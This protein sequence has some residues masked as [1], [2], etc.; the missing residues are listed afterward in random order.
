MNITHAAW[1]LL[2]RSFV[3]V[4]REGGL[5]QHAEPTDLFFLLISRKPRSLHS[6]RS[7][8]GSQT[9]TR[10]YGRWRG[11]RGI[12]SDAVSVRTTPPTKSSVVVSGTCQS[13]GKVICSD[14]TARLHHSV[15]KKRLSPK[16]TEGR[17]DVPPSGR[18]V[19]RDCH[20]ATGIYFRSGVP[21]IPTGRH[22]APIH[23][24]APVTSR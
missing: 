12:L 2:L 10:S 14:V 13:R 8:R 1:R 22:S 23:F 17:D 5:L 4:R 11:D 21:D 9:F 15:R 16:E 19:H 18:L 3:E 7:C 20:P 6:G 24:D